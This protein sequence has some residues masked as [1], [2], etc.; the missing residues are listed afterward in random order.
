MKYHH[1]TLSQII[2]YTITKHEINII[3]RVLTGYM[4]DASHVLEVNRKKVK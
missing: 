1:N 4:Y 3:E 2:Q